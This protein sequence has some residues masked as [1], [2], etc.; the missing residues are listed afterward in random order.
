MELIWL[1]VGQ[2]CQSDTR[3]SNMEGEKCSLRKKYC[4]HEETCE[5][6]LKG[7][8]LHIAKQKTINDRNT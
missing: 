4:K 1:G 5:L 3:T 8:D 2:S 7:A 6:V